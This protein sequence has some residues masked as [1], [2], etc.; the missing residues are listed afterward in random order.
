MDLLQHK[1]YVHLLDF[2]SQLHRPHIFIPSLP[3]IISPANKQHPSK[4]YDAPIH[5]LRGRVPGWRKANQDESEHQEHQRWDI[6]QQSVS[7]EGKMAFQKWL[8]ANAQEGHGADGDHVGKEEGDCAESGELVKG[9][10]GAEG[11][12]DEEDGEDRRR[13]DGV[14]RDV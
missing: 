2:P 8:V 12:A 7:A 6:D 1:M 3:P 5:A 4:D 13:E 9:D 14:E 10:G 11:D